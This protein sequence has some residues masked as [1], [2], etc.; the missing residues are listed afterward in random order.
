MK[1]ST[2]VDKV[3]GLK[4]QWVKVNLGGPE[5]RSGR[6]LAVKSDFIAIQ[7]E[8]D[9]VIYYQLDHVKGVSIN[10]NN[11]WKTS[12]K[13]K[14]H[15]GECFS[16]ILKEFKHR[17]VK[18]NRG[19]PESIEG[20]V[21]EISKKHLELIVGDEIVFLSIWHLKSVS[22]A[23]SAKHHS[24]KRSSGGKRSGGKKSSDKKDKSSD[25][26]K[27]S[28]KKDKC[29]DDKK[30]SG[31]KDK[32]SDDKKSSGK[33][34]KCSDDK[35]SSG[36]KDKC[37]YDKK[38]SGKKDKC[39][40]DKKKSSYDNKRSKVYD[41]VKEAHRSGSDKYMHNDPYGNSKKSRGSKGRSH[42]DSSK[43]QKPLSSLERKG[44]FKL[45]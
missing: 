11:Y 23:K 19:G 35:K 26:K 9:E 24:G 29:S 17:K 3:A 1:Y 39:S 12:R 44:W 10:A 43:Y 8:K 5:S 40:D 20:V 2:S 16:D 32:C 45:S 30:S 36:K 6:L 28:G 22:S 34:D 33:K 42:K 31:K 7:T 18:V 13:V 37:S 21:N 14:L 27:S 15:D 4:G 25:D 41:A 38:S